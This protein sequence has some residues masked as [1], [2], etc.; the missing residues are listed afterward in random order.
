[1]LRPSRI[2]L[3]AA[4]LAILAACGGAS[5]AEPAPADTA[6]SEP[7]PAAARDTLV[8]P[9][10]PR[11]DYTVLDSATADVDGDG[12]P[13]RIDLAATVEMGEDGLPL[14]EDG[15][16][17][18]IAVRDGADTYPL[19]QHFVP[20]GG[21]A[22]WIVA[23]DLAGPAAIL[24][25]STTRFAETG[26]TRLEKFVFDRARGGYVR[27]AVAEAF[28]TAQYRGPPDMPAL[29]PPTAREHP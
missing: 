5:R 3:I 25:Q 9:A 7:T 8:R 4:T 22:F 13:E 19:A 28:G 20:W 27:T 16:H 12:A 26:G 29:L 17:W 14:W 21:A 23:D 11:Y 6:D 18:M 24:V 2:P 10:A 15:H 1:M